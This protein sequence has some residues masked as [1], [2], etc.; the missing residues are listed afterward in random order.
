LGV[1]AL[2]LVLLLGGVAGGVYLS[3]DRQIQHQGIDAQ[4][5][6]Q[7]D[8]A[9]RRVLQEQQSAHAAA[10]APQREAEAEAAAK[11]AGAAKAA[12]ARAEKAKVAV[13]RKTERKAPATGSGDDGA[14]EAPA[15]KPK[16]FTGP[17]PKSCN[18]YSGSRKIAC[19]IVVGKG[20][21]ME[22]MGCLDRLW[23]K[24]SGWNPKAANPSS[25]AYGIPQALPGKK[26]ASAGA[27]W[28][29]NPAT[30]I[31]WGLGY[32]AGRYGNPCGAWSH[33]QSRGWY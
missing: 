5:V 26:M 3:Q 14:D 27:D 23:K 25:G 12:A 20:M 31:K 7:A 9:E 8:G 33:S 1:R 32:I 13:T 18:Q 30:Q 15:A 4:L 11:A 19:A 6:V 16:P 17:I 22:Q 21:G 29:S 10:V 28:K 24:E 2:S